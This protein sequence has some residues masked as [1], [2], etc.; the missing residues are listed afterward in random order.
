MQETR[1]NRG[2][3]LYKFTDTNGIECSVQ[4][5]SAA[6]ENRIWLGATKIGLKH[7]KAG[8]GWKD[9][10]LTD[11]IEEHYTANTR[12]HINQETAKELVTILQRFID[13]GEI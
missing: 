2:F 4:K 11:T 12:I 3:T 5:S 7:F 8:E 10:E 13:T 6:F 9:I 1:T